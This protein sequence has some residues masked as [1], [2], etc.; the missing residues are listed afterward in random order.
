MDTRILWETLLSLHSEIKSFY[1]R[2][3][4]GQVGPISPHLSYI[5]KETPMVLKALSTKQSLLTMPAVELA[6]YLQDLSPPQALPPHWPGQ[7]EKHL[8]PHR[9]DHHPKSCVVTPDTL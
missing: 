1:Y 3:P 5:L 7:G 9:L 2:S 8:G 6:V 4:S